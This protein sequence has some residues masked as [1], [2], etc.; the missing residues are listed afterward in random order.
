[1]KVIPLS[2]KAGHGKDT[3]AGLLKD[4]LEARGKKVLVTHYGD[5]IKYICK[6]FFN[7]NGLKDEAGRTLL[8]RVGTEGIR[9]K[10]ADYWVDFICDML[11]FFEG[12]WDYV[13]IPD[14][15]FPNEIDRLR[16]SGFDVQ[17]IRITRP[18]FTTLTEE[19][20]KHRSEAALD[21]YSDDRIEVVN[22]GTLQALMDKAKEITEIIL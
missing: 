2:G 21:N 9:S 6:M 5:L 16:E 17:H 10:A 1:M 14:A 13:L 20:Q 3:F 11:K 8:Q 22:N 18:G 12:E 15:R 4:N 19:Q 7:W